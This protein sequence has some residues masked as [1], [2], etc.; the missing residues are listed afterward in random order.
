[1]I[2]ALA[3]GAQVLNNPAYSQAAENAVQ[4]ILNNLVRSD[5]RLLAR[6]R[7]GEAAYPAYVDD[8]AFLVWGLIELYEAT[9]NVYYLQTALRFNADLLKL[10]GDEN[11]GL[12][13]YGKDSEQL[14]A[15]PKEVYDGAIPSGNSVAALN[16]LRLARVTGK[17]ELAETADQ[18]FKAFAGNINPYPAGYTFMLSALWFALSPGKEIVIAG[19]TTDATTQQMLAAVREH[20][21]PDSVVLLNTPELAELVP[22]IA[23]QTPQNGRPTTYI[24]EGYACQAPIT[25]IADLRHHL[26]SG[27]N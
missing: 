26:V 14:L 17:P 3:K 2:A 20:Y 6:Y 16:F 11:G 12:F 22:A 1:M 13:M 10:F 18:L 5:G 7:D 9:F 25:N 21:L 24:C 27:L 23:G 4:F 8:Y 19:D 15:R